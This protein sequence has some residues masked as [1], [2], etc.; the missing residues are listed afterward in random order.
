MQQCH[1]RY[2]WNVTLLR[3]RVRVRDRARARVG[4]RFGCHFGVCRVED[5]IGHSTLRRP[6]ELRVMGRV[7]TVIWGR[8]TG[9]VRDRLRFWLMLRFRRRV[10]LR[11]ESLR[12]GLELRLR[13][14]VKER[15]K[16][17]G[18][19]QRVES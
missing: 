5:N 8:G 13:L 11:V 2:G 6:P 16:V 3:V 14:E 1:I 4:R 10:M 19:S 9:K 15:V 7:S 12:K 18:P 17:R